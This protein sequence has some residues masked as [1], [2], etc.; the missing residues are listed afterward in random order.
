MR[1][2]TGGNRENQK[3]RFGELCYGQSAQSSQKRVYWVGFVI[4]ALYMYVSNAS[5]AK[6]KSS[7]VPFMVT[8]CE[9]TLI[10]QAVVSV[11]GSHGANVV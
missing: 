9:G 7:V 2:K 5:G 8:H 1:A 6:N 11:Q 10:L 4:I 3:T